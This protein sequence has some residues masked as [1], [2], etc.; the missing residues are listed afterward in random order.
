MDPNLTEGDN[1]L[2]RYLDPLLRQTGASANNLNEEVPS[3]L[4]HD[5]IEVVG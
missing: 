4:T 3:A 5:V 2:K 1:E